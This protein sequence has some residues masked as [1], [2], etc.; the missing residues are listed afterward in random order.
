MHAVP[1]RR[2]TGPDAVL[3][4]MG[5]AVGQAGMLLLTGI[6]GLPFMPRTGFTLAV[7][8][9]IAVGWVVSSDE[10]DEP[11]DGPP[12]HPAPDQGDEEH[13]EEHDE[14]GHPLGAA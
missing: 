9:L 11:D 8:A 2:L 4:V 5:L 6:Y 7:A 13:G 12:Q 14:E 1:A 3:L 10:A